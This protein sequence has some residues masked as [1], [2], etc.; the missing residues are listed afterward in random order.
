[1]VKLCV[2]EW[3][4]RPVFPTMLGVFVVAQVILLFG[5]YQRWWWQAFVSWFVA[6]PLT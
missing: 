5:F 6:F 3:E 1:M 4:R 2:T